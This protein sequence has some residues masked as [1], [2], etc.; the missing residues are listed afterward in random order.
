[1]LLKWIIE[2]TYRLCI[3]NRDMRK[4]K[5]D[6][7]R[8]HCSLNLQLHSRVFSVDHNVGFVLVKVFTVFKGSVVHVTK[9]LLLHAAILGAVVCTFQRTKLQIAL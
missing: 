1:M 8:F 9:P 4:V 5:L 3:C 7:C 2:Q 6:M